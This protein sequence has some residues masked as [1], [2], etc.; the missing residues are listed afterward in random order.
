M[1]VLTKGTASENIV[2]TLDEKKTLASPTYVIAFTNATTKDVISITLGTD[3]SAYKDRYNEFAIATL[4]AFVSAVA[5][6]WTYIVTEQTSNVQVE[7]G[8]MLLNPATDFAFTGYQP[9]TTYKGY[10][11]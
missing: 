3:L 7:V 11:G 8:R 10:A 2:L 1:I 4:T 9:A 5:G 6:Q